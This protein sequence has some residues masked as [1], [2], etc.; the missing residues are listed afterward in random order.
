MKAAKKI[1]EKDFALFAFF[2]AKISFAVNQGV[3][4]K[5]PRLSVHPRFYNVRSI[6]WQNQTY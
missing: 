4:D 5:N 6:T 2:A 3:I 1:Q